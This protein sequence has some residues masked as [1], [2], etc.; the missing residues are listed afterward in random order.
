MTQPEDRPAVSD[1][2]VTTSLHTTATR[3]A[4]NVIARLSGMFLLNYIVFGAWYAT[5]GLVLAT[6][7]MAGTI[8]LTYAFGALAGMVSPMFLGAI[9]DRYFSS[10]KVLGVA[11]LIAAVL[12][13]FMPTVVGT[14][15]GWSVIVL[16]FVYMLFFQ[17]TLGLTNSIAFR[18]LGNS[19]RIFPFVRV[20]ATVG[21][22]VA[23][24][25]VG[26]AGLSASTGIFTVAAVAGLV[27][28]A[29]SFTLPSTPP[30]G[31]GK[32]AIGDVIGAKAFRLFRDRNFTTFAI[33]ALLTTIS[34]GFYNSYA[35]S[36]L[37]AVGIKNVAGVLTIGQMSEVLFILTI[38][39]VLKRFG[40]K[41]GLLAGMGTWAVRFALFVFAAHD[42]HWL[43]I[44]GI[45]LHGI[46]NDF[47]LVLGAM[48][49][50]R[51]APPELTAQAQ[52][53][54]TWISSGAGIFAG[55]LIAGGI[56]GATITATTMMNAGAWTTL[57]TVPIAISV[58]TAILWIT[59][60]RGGSA[61]IEQTTALN[62]PA[63]ATTAP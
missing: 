16:V 25:A 35:S 59:L 46:C 38:P 56:Y 2:S 57:W 9:G 26:A 47:F 61:R 50:D 63:P 53:L 8:A 23:G 33:C 7:G 20:F 4:P 19:R 49:L 1:G 22:I 48:Y 31:K 52:S 15:N 37:S 13:F 36:Y 28:A 14:G 32:F 51:V 6:H 34:L 11:H 21:F 12:M 27:L 55:S 18:H 45:A 54:F 42:L 40:M 44:V 10:Q 17:P 5:L 41:I 62:I 24:L 39:F 60:F 3:I 29:Y 43:A 58:V 30:S